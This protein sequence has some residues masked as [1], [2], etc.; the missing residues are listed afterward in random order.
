MWCALKTLRAGICGFTNVYM[1]ELYIYP[2]INTPLSHRPTGEY[3]S[4]PLGGALY[5]KIRKRCGLLKPTPRLDWLKMPKMFL[6]CNLVTDRLTAIGPAT[7]M[8]LKPLLINNATSRSRLIKPRPGDN[9]FQYMVNFAPISTADFGVI[10]CY[11]KGGTFRGN[12]GYSI[13]DIH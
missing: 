7:W 11:S 6:T 9:W 8:L 3:L 10:V 5:W 2:K 1:R 12:G 13:G 4:T